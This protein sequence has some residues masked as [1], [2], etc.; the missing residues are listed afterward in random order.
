LN[1]PQTLSGCTDTS[2]GFEVEFTR[3]GTID[4]N[5]YDANV[6]TQAAA[7]AINGTLYHFFY[8]G[9]PKITVVGVA[10]TT[11]TVPI[12]RALVGGSV[13]TNPVFVDVAP[14]ANILN[15]FRRTGNSITVNGQNFLEVEDRWCSENALQTPATG[16]ASKQITIPDLQWGVTNVGTAEV[17]VAFDSQLI[18]NNQVLQTGN[19]AAGVFLPLAT[20]DFFFH[21]QHSTVHVFRFAAPNQPGCFARPSD[22][23]FFEDPTFT[24]K[25]D[26][27][28]ALPETATN[29]I[30]N[31]RNF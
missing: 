2:C 29:R 5:L 30:N 13:A 12:N 8:N 17:T 15:L 24:V 18:A 28:N 22:P 27:N 3:T 11:V 1:N 10:N 7:L 20:H 21:R 4:I 6:G 23:D 26:V 25:V 16:S 14:R 9:A 19:V 31:A